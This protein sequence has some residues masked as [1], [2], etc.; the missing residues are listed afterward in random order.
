METQA[1]ALMTSEIRNKLNINAIQTPRNFTLNI[2]QDFV[3]TYFKQKRQCP[4]N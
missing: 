2:F 3:F 1:K 4:W